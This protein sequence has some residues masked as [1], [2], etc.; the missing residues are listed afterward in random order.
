MPFSGGYW[1]PAPRA[2]YIG[3]IV[4]F[5]SGEKEPGSERRRG[6][7]PVDIAAYLHGNYGFQPTWREA[8]EELC[9][10]KIAKGAYKGS[11]WARPLIGYG[12][13]VVTEHVDIREWYTI[14]RTKK[15]SAPPKQA[16]KPWKQISPA[17][18]R[19]YLTDWI[20]VGALPPG[21]TLADA[22]KLHARGE[23]SGSSITN[24]LRRAAV[25]PLRNLPILLSH[26]Q[27][28]W[29]SALS[30]SLINEVKA[31]LETFILSHGTTKSKSSYRSDMT[32]I[33]ISV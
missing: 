11:S 33:S 24:A 16:R 32:S 19:T 5:L 22:A 25:D 18:Q 15:T 30:T 14:T 7:R 29:R 8:M 31:L 17:T 4:W 13:Q 12:V 6:P 3:S 20:R 26:T 28:Q 2:T 23:P 10:L 27:S 9:T 1:N 21:A